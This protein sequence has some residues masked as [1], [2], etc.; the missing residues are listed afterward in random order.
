MVYLEPNS[1]YISTQP[2]LRGGFHWSLIH[3]DSDGDANRHHWAALSAA[4]PESY[5]QQRVDLAARD[6]NRE[7]LGYFKLPGYVPV[8]NEQLAEFARPIFAGIRRLAQAN[9]ADG[10]TCRTWLLRVLD[11]LRE[12]ELMGASLTGD[13]IEGSVKERS[14][15]QEA[16]YLQAFLR[17]KSYNAVVEEIQF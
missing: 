4:Q 17:G 3:T 5:I 11:A 9:R 14:A 13:E 7:V 1:L 6:V 16:I 15:A 12:N 10:V 8:S 2:L